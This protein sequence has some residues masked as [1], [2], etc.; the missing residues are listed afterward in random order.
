MKRLLAMIG[1]A[2]NG[3]EYV[4][5]RQPF[6]HLRELGYELVTLGNRL[7][8]E[9]GPN[10]YRPTVSVFDG[11]DG[12]IFPQMILS[13]PLQDGSKLDLVGSICEY[14]ATHSLPIIYSVDDYVN[15]VERHNPAFES[16]Q[17]SILNVQTILDHASAAFV[18]TPA[19]RD[20]FSPMGVATHMLPNAIDPECW[21]GRPGRS[22]ELRVG[23]AGS[24]SHL[25]DLL[26]V[27][28]AIRE[29]QCRVD[30]H[31]VLFGLVHRPLDVETAEARELLPG[32]DGTRRERALKFLELIAQLSEI[33]HVHVPFVDID[34]YFEV[35]PELDLDVGICPLQE[36]EFNRHKSALK[37]YE[38]AMCGT[39]TVASAVEAY[40]DEVSITVPNEQADW[41]TVL[42]AVLRAPIQRKQELE[43][44]RS[45]VLAERNIRNLRLDWAEALETTLHGG[46]AT[47]ATPP[48]HGS[49]EAR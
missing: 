6:R 47:A 37:F 11:I 33:R 40:R 34:T 44:Q 15:G 26:M 24:S 22:G 18:T 39:L 29:L 8:L 30:F 3:V 32:L 2:S 10:G 9:A 27:L 12:L 13:P 1:D 43:R 41:V 16:I 46:R 36:T 28:P 14:A 38:Y 48:R 19:L 45:F 20:T 23:W 35:L 49:E 5:F 7:T 21:K 17:A 25:D 31:F 4:R 42:E